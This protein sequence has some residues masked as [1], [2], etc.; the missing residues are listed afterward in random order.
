M[1]KK[2]KYARHAM[3]MSA[4][5]AALLCAAA[6]A[7]AENLIGLTNTNALVTFDTATP[8]NG[9]ARVTI[10]GCSAPIKPAP[11]RHLVF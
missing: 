3:R 2:V 11:P 7:R 4:L 9:S 8:A 5:V 6:G 10:T 1:S